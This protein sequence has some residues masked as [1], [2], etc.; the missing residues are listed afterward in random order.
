MKNLLH[1]WIVVICIIVGMIGTAKAAVPSSPTISSI[2]VI[3]ASGFNITINKSP[4]ANFYVISVYSDESL[5]NLVS[6]SLNGVKYDRLGGITVNE[7]SID[8]RGLASGV[9]YFFSV[10]AFNSEGISPELINRIYVASNRS[11]GT[12]KVSQI[13]EGANHVDAGDIDGDGDT[14]IVGLDSGS[15]QLSWWPNED[16]YYSTNGTSIGIVSADKFLLFDANGD[17]YLDIVCGYKVP[18]G[19]FF[20]PEG[21]EKSLAL[22]M[23][24]GSGNFTESSIP[25]DSYLAP[26]HIKS[27]DIDGDGLMISSL[28]MHGIEILFLEIHISL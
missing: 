14:D 13:L 9:Y 2:E 21:K 5:S 10:S 1:A 7:S 19:Y 27:G 26:V 25:T 16:G 15:G 11:N 23:N 3:D 8:V 20:S 24:D 6:G 28:Q 12:F 22:F 18:N 17:S 4:D